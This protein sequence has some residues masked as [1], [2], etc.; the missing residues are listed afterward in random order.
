MVLGEANGLLK[1]AGVEL[2]GDAEDE[3]NVLEVRSGDVYGNE[4]EGGDVDVNSVEPGV[5]VENEAGA[6]CNEANVDTF[7]E[8]AKLDCNGC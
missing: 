8:G 4:A 7:V 3:A 1:G 2:A 6:F 5:K